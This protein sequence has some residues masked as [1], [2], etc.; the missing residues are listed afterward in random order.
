[1]NFGQKDRPVIKANSG[2]TFALSPT[3]FSVELS[4]PGDLPNCGPDRKRFGVGNFSKDLKVHR[5]MV[6][7]W[8]S[9][10]NGNLRRRH[11]MKW[12]RRRGLARSFSKPGRS[13][14]RTTAAPETRGSSG[15]R[16]NAESCYQRMP[17]RNDG[18]LR[19]IQFS[20]FLQV[21]DGLFD[22]FTLRSGAGLGIQ[23]NV[24]AFFGG[25]K[26]R[27]QFHGLT[28]LVKA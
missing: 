1:M 2:N 14:A 15:M 28:P 12:S 9:C 10:V 23:G 20:C 6:T 7:N 19:Q 17:R 11:N 22:G 21:G 13:N 18:K 4:Q 3:S 5:G 26:Y 27:G 25:S 16:G 8:A 24:T